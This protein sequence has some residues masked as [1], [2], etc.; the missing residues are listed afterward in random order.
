MLQDKS[1]RFK[2]YI[3]FIYLSWVDNTLSIAEWKIIEHYIERDKELNKSEKK[4]LSTYLDENHTPDEAIFSDWKAWIS[5]QSA[6][7]N[8][9]DGYPLS[10]FAQAISSIDDIE[11]H[12]AI[13]KN[14]DLRPSQYKHVFPFV[15]KEVIQLTQMERDEIAAFFTSAS[16]S[17]LDEL[18][19]IFDDEL[20]RWREMRI[21]EAFRD[22]VL[23]QVQKLG[24]Y[25]YGAVSYPVGY[26]G[27]DDLAAYGVI[28]E[29]LVT[30]DPSLAVRFGVQYGLFGGSIVNLGTEKHHKKWL[31]D[32]G[33]GKMLGC[34]A[35]TETQH[36]SN[37]RHLQTRATY[38]KESDTFTIHTPTE[39]D[40]KEFI[41]NALAARYATVFAQLIANGKNHGV[42]AFVV[43]M[44]TENGELYDGIKAEDDGYK[45]GLNGVDNGKIW[46]DNVEIPRF[47]LLNKFGN[48]TDEGNYESPIESEGRRFFTMLGTLIGGRICVGKGAIKGAQ[49]TLALSIKYALQRRQFG[50]DNQQNEELLIDYPSHQKR[51]LPRLARSMTLH[52]A[53]E[54]IV[55]QYNAAEAGSTREI[56]SEVAALKA[57]ATWYADKTNQ[58]CREA[59]GGAGYMLRNR[60]GDI[61]NDLD[62]FTTFE[63][64]N[65]VLTQLAAKG[66]LSEFQ[67]QFSSEDFSSVMRYVGL[68]VMSTIAEYN[69][70]YRGR[71]EKSHLRDPKFHQHAVNYRLEELKLS[72]ASRLRSLIQRKIDSYD[73]F[74]RVQ[75]HVIEVGKAYADFL[76]IDK[77]YNTAFS[78]IQGLSPTAQKI[79]SELACLSSLSIIY[80]H[81]DW[82]LGKSYI[83][84][85]KS[86]AIRN[87]IEQLCLELRPYLP[88]LIHCLN[89][90]E[91]NMD[92]EIG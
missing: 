55:Q 60:L 73:A 9:Q 90:P 18:E 14:L 71:T 13:E 43:P 86:K 17:N 32:I 34:F 76:E 88:D 72:L 40:N 61:K 3:P 23:K 25:G 69:P 12:K 74:L 10:I 77:F 84:A 22:R 5:G 83:N 57:A 6:E 2:S 87:Q 29:K 28:F 85:S 53:F 59:C 20:F 52:A 1:A 82:Y 44:R 75:N 91:A 92:I 80:K 16:K 27:N 4:F 51:L 36:G 26:G 15:Q 41:G 46:F 19:N 54:D 7:I 45:L 49:Y 48:I 50:R 42:H 65:T 11:T 89:V 70:L 38:N 78:R 81:N 8:P 24:E 58:A 47:N 31:S 79:I 39:K 64:D 63:G 30:L 37:V 35:M 56:E 67:A 33:S 66:L 62:I 68:K 21:K